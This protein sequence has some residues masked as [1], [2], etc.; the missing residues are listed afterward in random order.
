M[1][2]AAQRWQ[3]APVPELPEVEG[4]A[5]FLREHA[6]GRV[7]ARIDVAAFNVLKTFD[8]SP[9]S[10][11]RAR[12]HRRPAARQVARRRRRRPAPGLPP[13]QGG[14]AALVREAQP[15]AAA[16][17]QEPDRAARR[18][19]RRNRLRPDRGRHPQAVGRVRRPRPGVRPADR[20]A[21]PGPAGR[22]LRP[23]GFRRPAG[24]QA[25][26]DQGAAARPV[27]A[28]RRR[29]T[30][31]PTRCCTRPSSRRTRWPAR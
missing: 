22:R 29:A 12:G 26:P 5:A 24:R 13:V 16:P 15:D 4:L 11:A 1:A 18:P 6:V 19:G 2:A 23:G 27:G 20:L 9:G 25:H 30:P 17:R 8:P 28:R 7:V 21:G 14:L 3:T 31:T 10:P